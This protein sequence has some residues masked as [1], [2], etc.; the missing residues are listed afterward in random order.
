[1]KAEIGTAKEF[2]E[3]FDNSCMHYPEN[4]K[5]FL[6]SLRR[7]PEELLAMV[8]VAFFTDNEKFLNLAIGEKELKDMEPNRRKAISNCSNIFLE[9]MRGSGFSKALGSSPAGRKILY[10]A[11]AYC[12]EKLFDLWYENCGVNTFNDRYERFTDEVADNMLVRILEEMK[13]E[14]SP[15]QYTMAEYDI[16][17]LR[18][19]IVS[20]EEAIK[21]PDSI[22][23]T[24][25]DQE[26]AL[27]SAAQLNCANNYSLRAIKKILLEEF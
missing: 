12:N 24:L 8:R 7:T 17:K 10:I 26:I 18:G 25:S 27:I 4:V 11:A 23:Y 14:L 13:T 9:R 19:Q 2:A 16:L 1:M 5:E 3:I 6:F 15:M 20:V 22:R 21:N